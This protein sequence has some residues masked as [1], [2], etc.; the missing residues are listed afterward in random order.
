MSNTMQK[1]RAKSKA[2]ILRDGIEP[3]HNRLHGV[4]VVGDEVFSKKKW[5]GTANKHI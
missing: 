4:A 1:I 5:T 3:N 2:H